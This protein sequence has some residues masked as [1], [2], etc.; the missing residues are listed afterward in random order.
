MNDAVTTARCGAV[1][2]RESAANT[3]QGSPFCPDRLT[4]VG[5]T[6]SAYLRGGL[7]PRPPP[8]GLPGIVLG[9][10]GGRGA[11][12]LPPLPPEPEPPEPPPEPLPPLPLCP[13]IMSLL[14]VVNGEVHPIV[15]LLGWMPS[16]LENVIIGPLLGNSGQH[17]RGL[18]AS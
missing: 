5:W 15:L 11:G 3:R 6:A 10:F 17:V 13:P 1:T 2:Q 12:A 16:V 4:D 7:F 18:D 9:P 8:E 14:G